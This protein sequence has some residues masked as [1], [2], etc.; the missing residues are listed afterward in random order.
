[1]SASRTRTSKMSRHFIQ[2][3]I[4]VIDLQQKL[5]R[6]LQPRVQ[7]PYACCLQRLAII[8]I[9]QAHIA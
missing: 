1:M 9:L 6:T 7:A 5:R 8:Q 3:H 2:M 4:P